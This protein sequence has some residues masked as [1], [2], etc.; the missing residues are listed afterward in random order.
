MSDIKD[1]A[2]VGGI[3]LTVFLVI[4]YLNKQ[5][6]QGSFWTPDVSQYYEE[7]TSGNPFYDAGLVIGS[8][9]STFLANIQASITASQ[10]GVY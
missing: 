2:V 8:W 6:Q 5:A 7:G 4:D 3:A 9:W 10:G 1:I